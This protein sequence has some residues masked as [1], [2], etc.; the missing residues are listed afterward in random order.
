MSVVSYTGDNPL[1]HFLTFSYCHT[2][3]LSTTIIF[4][5]YTVMKENPLYRYQKQH[6]FYYTCF[7]VKNVM[8][9]PHSR[10]QSFRTL[11]WYVICNTSTP[12]RVQ[13]NICPC[14]YRHQIT[15]VNIYNCSLF[16]LVHCQ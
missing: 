9:I 2:L 10:G 6:F 13:L 8:L 5:L 16:C 4:V 14:K 1:S 11:E 12:V 3:P 15:Y 7:P